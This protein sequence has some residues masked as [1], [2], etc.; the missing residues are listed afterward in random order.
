VIIGF[1][2]HAAF[3]KAS[4]CHFL[5][6]GRLKQ[7]ALWNVGQYLAFGLVTMIYELF[8]LRM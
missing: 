4:S 2:T 3:V 5:L 6:F 1:E 8:E 7:L